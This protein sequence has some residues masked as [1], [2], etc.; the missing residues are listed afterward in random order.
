M[1]TSYECIAEPATLSY[2][3]EKPSAIQRKADA[4]RAACRSSWRA[5]R[6]GGAGCT[7]PTFN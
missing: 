5:S 1:K 7:R 3:D 2:T 6:F 4:T